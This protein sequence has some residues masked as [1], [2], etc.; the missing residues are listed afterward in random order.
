MAQYVE[1][2]LAYRVFDENRNAIDQET[3]TYTG[4]WGCRE[5]STTSDEITSDR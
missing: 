2:R 1:A 3:F 5:T 4:L